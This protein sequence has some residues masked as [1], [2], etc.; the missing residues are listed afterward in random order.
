MP[1]PG[2]ADEGVEEYSGAER[3]EGGFSENGK[4]A[5]LSGTLLCMFRF[6]ESEGFVWVSQ[7]T[8]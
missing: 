1:G 2:P 6:L 7:Q 8:N 4:E 3:R 5:V